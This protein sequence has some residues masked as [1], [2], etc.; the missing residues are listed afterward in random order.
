[1]AA[2]PATD[3]CRSV[4]AA[5]PGNDGRAAAATDGRRNGSYGHGAPGVRWATDGPDATGHASGNSAGYA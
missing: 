2:G 5:N 1:M 4:P 3:G